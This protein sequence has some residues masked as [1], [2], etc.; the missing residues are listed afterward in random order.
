[1][2]KIIDVS[3]YQGAIAWK[4]V[5]ES[6]VEI[7][8]LRATTRNKQPDAR[9]YENMEALSRTKIVTQFYKF[10]YTRTGY[11]AYNEAAD[12]IAKIQAS[13]VTSYHR[14]L[15]LDLEGWDNRDYTKKE[16]FDVIAAYRSACLD[17]LWTLGIYANY[18]YFKNIIPQCFKT[19]PAWVARYNDVLGDIR[20]FEPVYWQYSSKGKI[21][22]IS[23]NVDVNREV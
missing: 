12:T 4:S 14:M 7:A 1:M 20:P 17:R 22:G 11:E 21:P 23:G 15:W 2:S 6:G 16:A 19:L 5:E 18:Y 8:I 10:A 13:P 9:L 3:A